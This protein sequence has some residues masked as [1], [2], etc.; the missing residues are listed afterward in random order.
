MFA[1]RWKL[2][3]TLTV[4]LVL[5]SAACNSGSTANVQNPPPPPQQGITVAF[6]STPPSSVVIGSTA[7]LAAV[8]NND[9]TNSGVDWSCTCSTAATIP[10][11][12]G[13]LSSP[14]TSSGQAV[15]YNPPA[16]MVGNEE[17]V[18]ISAFATADHSENVL[19]SISVTA[20][21]S[22]L[23]G[24]YVLQAQGFENGSPY[25]VAASI[26][27]DGNGN[28]TSGEQTVNLVDLT[29]VFNSYSGAISPSGSSYFLGPDGRGTL[30]IN[31]GTG[32][33]VGQET[34]TLA[35]LSAAHLLIAASPNPDGPSGVSASGTMDLQTS[36]G[37]A[38]LSGGYAF[39]LGG[40]DFNGAGPV[41]IG[42]ILNVDN[43]PSNPNNI[44]G[45]GSIADEN[46]FETQYQLIR[47][48]GNV[49]APDTLGVVNLALTLNSGLISTPSITLKGYFVDPTHLILIEDDQGGAGAVAGLATAQGSSTGVFTDVSFSG[50]YVFD[51]LGVD[52]SIGVPDTFTA[53]GV[54]TSDGAGSL[55][56]GY[57]DSA[58]QSLISPTTSTPTAIG[59]PFSGAYLSYNTIGRLTAT[60]LGFAAPN[61]SYRP[62][63][64][65]YLAD[66]GSSAL[67]LGYAPDT[68]VF[69]FP[70]IATGVA[71]PQSAGPFTVS[72]NY[73]VNIAQQNGSEFDGTGQMTVGSSSVA[74]VLDV[75]ASTGQ[76][77]TG[78]IASPGCSSS[79]VTGCFAASFSNTTGSAGLQGTN[80]NDSSAFDAD[81][82]MIDSNHG[83]FIEN[84]LLQQGAP[85]VSL[86]Y[87]SVVTQLPQNAAKVGAQIH[88]SRF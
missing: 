53:A 28:V 34:F 70:F 20:F 42:G 66:S 67:V 17:V 45:T 63:F 69:P 44:S 10:G 37:I 56:S 60:T 85:Q 76:L 58:F 12:C 46:V 77:F 61:G 74:G 24:T 7:S 47:T 31:P 9:S 51:L 41:G 84:D 36:T 14:H 26:V 72:G 32:S 40:T 43:Q 39:V 2:G 52:F 8:V 30:T 64:N 81:I 73:G 4:A 48:S 50:T 68:G 57:L 82:Y 21:G 62:R 71:Y 54:V 11:S 15:T 55:T 59:G 80:I 16:S 35:Y 27:L 5:V 38:S 13:S 29:G 6:Q 88:K 33:P 1:Q 86:G 79:T 22:S 75:G 25:Q 23:G 78:T 49:S 87:L 65:F 19:T 3:T 18:N 83:F